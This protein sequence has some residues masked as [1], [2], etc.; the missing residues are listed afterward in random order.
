[1]SKATLTGKQGKKILE[2]FEDTPSEQVQDLLESGFLAFLRDANIAN[3]NRDEF[4]RVCGLQS[5]SPKKSELLLEMVGTVKIPTTSKFIAKDRFVVNTD[6]NAPVKIGG[7]SGNFTE[8]FLKGEG[9]TEEPI[10][11]HTLRYARLRQSSVDTPIIAELGGETKAETTLSA[12]FSLMEKQKSGGDGALLNNGYAN[13][14]Y[15][16]D[17]NN[18]L[19]AVGVGWRDVGWFMLAYPVEIPGGWNDGFRVFSSN[20]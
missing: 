17:Q 15:I 4:R 9:K 3:I 5:L 6:D 11:E 16:R 1:M 2:V 20:S 10:S 12:T 7:L 8:W 18:T 14:F 19:R 13:I